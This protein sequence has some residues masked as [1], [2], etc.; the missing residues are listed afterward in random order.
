MNAAARRAMTAAALA[1]GLMTTGIPTATAKDVGDGRL[2]CNS[3]EICMNDARNEV[4]RKHYWWNR[5]YNGDQ[6]FDTNQGIKR[7]QV[8]DDISYVRNKDSRCRVLLTNVRFGADQ[9]WRAFNDGLLRQVGNG[10]NNK[11]GKHERCK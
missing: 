9:S 6:W 11:P 2:S 5:T 7:G 10:I 8:K 3:G 1:M 4:L